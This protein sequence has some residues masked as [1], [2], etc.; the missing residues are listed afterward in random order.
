MAHLSNS[1]F[2]PLSIA[3]LTVSDTRNIDSDTSGQALIDGLAVNGSARLVG[4]IAGVSRL[5]QS[6]YIYHYA[7]A[8]LAGVA[9]VLFFFLTLPYVWPTLSR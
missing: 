3:V 4:W 9:V 5:I 2:Q 7:F 1:E 6:G 8:M